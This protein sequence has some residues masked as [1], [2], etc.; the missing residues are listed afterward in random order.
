MLVDNYAVSERAVGM[1]EFQEMVM[2]FHGNEIHQPIRN[3]YTPGE[4][5]LHWHGQQVFQRPAREF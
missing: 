1:G 5:Y 2:A 3:S 4:E